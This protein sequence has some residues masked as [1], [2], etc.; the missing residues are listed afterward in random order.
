MVELELGSVYNQHTR[1]PLSRVCLTSPG[2]R[3]GSGGSGGGIVEPEQSCVS[4][5]NPLAKTYNYYSTYDV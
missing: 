2:D 5:V 3:G 1:Y 4:K